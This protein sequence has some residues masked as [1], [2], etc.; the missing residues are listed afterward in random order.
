MKRIVLLFLI[1]VIPMGFLSAQKLL[2]IYKNGPVKLVA[3]KTYGAKNN[4]ETLFNLYYD[5][6]TKNVGR[7][8]DKKII[9]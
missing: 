7:E 1:L 3:D 5:T 4:W 8:E 9:V 2:D 6:I